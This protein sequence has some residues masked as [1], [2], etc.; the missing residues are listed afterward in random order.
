MK[1][2]LTV[3]SRD[4]RRH[5]DSAVMFPVCDVKLS[6]EWRVQVSDA[7]A[8]WIGDVIGL[9]FSLLLLS[10]VLE[11]NLDLLLR[12]V[13]QV[14]ELLFPF[15]V[16]VLGH[17]EVGLELGNLVATE[18]GPLTSGRVH[19]STGSARRSTACSA[20]ARSTWRREASALAVSVSVGKG[21][22]GRCSTP[23]LCNEYTRYNKESA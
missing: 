13:G 6:V 8:R 1:S 5:W 2:F 9:R 23:K 22:E 3:N 17:P 11:P 21:S 20:T 18:N 4:A 10:P 16:Y 15:A 14:R 19:S 7:A 12:Q